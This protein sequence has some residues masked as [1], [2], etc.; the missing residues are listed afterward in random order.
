MSTRRHYLIPTA[1]AV[2]A[3]PAERKAAEGRADLVELLEDRLTPT[4]IA[5]LAAVLTTQL[6]GSSSASRRALFLAEPAVPA[7]R[8]RLHSEA[9]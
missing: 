2:T 3:S 7:R 6:T 9:R 8:Q 4:E 1:A 5:R